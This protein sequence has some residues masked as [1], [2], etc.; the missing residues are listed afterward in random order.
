MTYLDFLPK[1]IYRDVASVVALWATLY[2]SKKKFCMRGLT[3]RSTVLPLWQDRAWKCF[4][5]VSILG[6]LDATLRRS[7]QL[8]F[9]IGFRRFA[10][11][12]WSALLLRSFLY[13]LFVL[14]AI[15]GPLTTNTRDD[16]C[17]S[18]AATKARI[19]FW[20]S[21]LFKGTAIVL[22][23]EWLDA[24]AAD[25]EKWRDRHY[26]V[27]MHPHGLL[28]M[29][30]IL[31]GLT[32]VGGGL[33]GRTSSGAE[34]PEASDPGPLLHQH[35]FRKMKLRA[36]VA[37]GAVGLFPGFFEM[38]TKL[39]AFECTKPFIAERLRE[40]KDVAIFVGGATE[41]VYATPGRYVCYISKHKGFVKLALEERVDILPMWTFG[42]EA[43]FPQAR[44]K[45][46]F[47]TALIQ[48]AQEATGLAVPPAFAGLPRLPALTLVAGVPVS[49][50]DLWP[51]SVGGQVSDKAVEEGHRRYIQ[52][53]RQL[54]DR[55]KALV[56]GGH[57]NGVI[58]FI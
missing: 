5:Y 49:L 7:G 16:K 17:W 23:E 22:S 9:G 50:E 57:E 42:D 26:V 20:I 35:F 19:W 52:A 55:N 18:A 15:K 28:P 32:W 24:S 25:R 56:P 10:I 4:L 39:G 54:F 46:F 6:I 34:V 41:S 27:A 8:L 1:A 51:A 30:A 43:I 48:W 40:G 33:R 14:W 13:G 31:A 45:P 37:S 12:E 36:A 29:G 11:S 38:F 2:Y 3:Y 58:E 21:K 53:Q 44:S 47:L